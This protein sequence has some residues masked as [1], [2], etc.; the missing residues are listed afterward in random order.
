VPV[1]ALDRADTGA[2]V[3]GRTDLRRH[4]REQVL[5]LDEFAQVVAEEGRR[6][7]VARNTGDLDVMH[8]QHHRAR[9][10]ALRERGTHR[11]QLPHIAPAA[12]ELG[13]HRRGQ[14]PDSLQ[15][16][17]RFRRKSRLSINV[18]GMPGRNFG[19]DRAHLVQELGSHGR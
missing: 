2:R 11:G 7:S 10:A 16:G 15:G 6:Q 8:R 13:G 4:R 14:C 17:Q 9:A 3:A 12:A 1:V 5:L 19:R 18:I